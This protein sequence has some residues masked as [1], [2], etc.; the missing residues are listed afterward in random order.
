MS[1]YLV[2]VIVSDFESKTGDPKD[3][4]KYSVYANPRVSHQLNYSLSV[5]KPTIEF[6][7]KNLGIDYG[8]PKLDMI[9]LPDFRY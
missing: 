7:E 4:Y 8:L 9:A 5:M 2:A 3:K 6:F 1:T